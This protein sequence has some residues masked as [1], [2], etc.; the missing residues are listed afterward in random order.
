M[1]SMKLMKKPR[2]THSWRW[3]AF[4][5]ALLIAS[6]ACTTLTG[7]LKPTQAPPDTA[8]AKATIAATATRA[9]T[10]TK[11][12]S[13]TPAPTATPSSTATPMPGANVPL[14]DHGQ[15]LA[16]Q[17]IDSQIE[18]N[19]AQE[20][21]QLTFDQAMDAASTNAALQITDEGGQAVN[22]KVEW[23]DER[24][25]QFVPTTKLQAGKTYLARLDNSAASAAG[26][27]L[28]DRISLEFT[29][30]GE[31]Q[32]SQVF[33]ADGS[34][35]VASNAVI[36]VIFNR[37][38][39]P[40]VIAEEQANLPQPL[41]FDPPAAGEGEWINTSV[42]AFH[43]KGL[44][45]STAYR[46]SIA[47]GLPDALGE[48]SLAQ[49]FTWT[50]T[51]RSPGFVSYSLFNGA[52]GEYV[53]PEAYF[54]NVVPDA[55]FSIVFEQPM[56]RASVE[57]AISLV[58]E[59]GEAAP[60]TFDWKMEDTQVLI[61]PTVRL[62]LA[63][64][65]MLNLD[66]TAQATNG[67]EL[68]QG[69]QWPFSSVP[70]PDYWSMPSDGS[71]QDYYDATFSLHFVSPMRLDSLKD[72]V[73][74]KPA[75]SQP[76]EWYYYDWDW[77]LN[78]YNALQP[79][80]SYEVRILPGAEDLYGNAIQEERVVRFTTAKVQSNA[81]LMM[82]YM[83]LYRVGAVQEFY[84]NYQRVSNL[85]FSLYRLSATQFFNLTWPYNPPEDA[86]VWTK[87]LP[88]NQTESQRAYNKF[89]LAGEDTQP[90][91]PGFYFLGMDAGGVAH[92][93]KFVDSRTLIIAN[94]SLNLKT[95]AT[96]GL[97]WLTDLNSGAPLADAPV[98]IY[99]QDFKPIADGVTGEDGLLYLSLP[100][101]EQIWNA[102]Y[103]LSDD[104][105]TFAYASNDTGSG[106]NPWDFGIW[107]AY[108][109]EPA[110][111]V[112]YLYTDRPIYRPGQPV[113]FK[114]IVRADDDLRYSLPTATDVRL[115]ARTYDDEVIY[116]EILPL[117]TYGSFSG[118]FELDS[119]A[120]LGYYSM[121]VFVSGESNPVGNGYFTVA[122]YRKPEFIVNVSAAPQELLGGENFEAT[123]QADFYSGGGVGSA[124]VYWTLT[125]ENYYFAPAEEY[126]NFSFTD[127]DW[128]S[129]YYWNGPY[130]YGEMVAQGSGVTDANGKL[131][132]SVPAALGE[133]GGSRRLTFEATVS[134]PTG[135]PVSA[136]ASVTAH[137]SQVYAG[138][139]SLSYVG[140]ADKPMEIEV[141]ALDWGSEPV[142]G[143]T[144]DIEVVER[145]WS[146]IQKQDAQGRVTWEATVEETPVISFTA[147]TLDEKGLGR[148][149]FTPPNG[150]LFKAR[151]IAHDSLGNISR[152]STYLWVA[153]RD[154]IP[155]RVSNDRGFQL[156]SDRKSY[157]PGDTAEL[158]IASPFQ[159]QPYALVT[160]ERGHIR[161]YEVIRLES[162]SQVYR[163]PITADM[164]PNVYVSVLIVKGVDETSSKPDFRL[165]MLELKVDTSQQ[166]LKVELIPDKPQAGPG[167]TVTYQVRTTDLSGQPVSAE[168]SLSLSDLAALSLADPN[169]Q[170]LLDFFYNRRGLAVKTAVS[171]VN[172]IEDYNAVLQEY[173]ALG[174]GM[175]AGGGKGSDEWGVTA[176]RQ[177]FPDTAFWEGHLVTDANGEASVSVTLPDNLTTWR[178]DARAVTEDTRV[179]QTTLDLISTKPLLLRPQTPRFF[180]AGD[181]AVLG[182][183]VHN[184]T[185][186]ALSVDVS[187]QAE[188]LTLEGEAAQVIEI[189]AR[190]QAYVTWNVAVAPEATRVDVIFM[191]KSGEYEDATRPT[192]GVLDGQGIPVYRFEAPET[193][194]TAGI[195]TQAGATIEAI[196]LPLNFPVS[197]G[198]LTVSVSPSLA[199]GLADGLSYLE[200]YPYDCV[201]QT[202]SKFLPNVVSL[203]AMQAAGVS[204]P[205]LATRLEEEVYTALQRLYK[206]QNPDGGWGWWGDQE[207]NPTTSAYATFGLAELRLAGYGVDENVL[208][209]ALRYLRGQLRSFK[210]VS[211]AEP[212]QMN[213][214]AFILYVMAR[215]GEGA[216]FARLV[217]LYDLRE[218]LAL[219]A[220]A[221]LAQTIAWGDPSDPRIQTLLSDFNTAAINSATGAHWEE[222]SRDW[223]NW[224][225]DTRTTAIVLSALAELDAQNPLNA[226]AVRW[227][228]SNRSSGGH[229]QGTQE[230][231]WTILALTHWITASGE[232]NADYEYAI[233]LNGERL[234]GGVANRDTLKETYTL[235]LSVADLLKDEANRLA[236]A[237]SEGPGNLYYTAHLTVDLPVE[238]ISALD[239]GII[240]SR[241]YYRSDDR[242]TPV[243]EAAQG[244]LVQ[245]KLTIVVQHD[246]HY[247]VIDDPLP[248]GLEAV[249]QSL[250]TSQQAPQPDP[251]NYNWNDFNTYG[252]GWWIFNHV[253][254]RD[255]RVVLSAD[256]LPEGTYTYSYLARASTPGVFRVI[257][258]T[259]QEFYFPEVYGRGEGML[260]T[261]TP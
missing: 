237:R 209:D 186:E 128:D 158:L 93:G 199:A 127:I 102:R 126:T 190:Q 36:T 134:D 259:A 44:S 187:I 261:V 78:F 169:S 120:T 83:P 112:G 150:G 227:L 165:G 208:S 30:V 184:N 70:Y 222:S 200:N 221:Y 57:K 99:D 107:D 253:E 62:A 1:K 76:P 92:E 90:L 56:Q 173:V 7:P 194:G 67:G 212:Y 185:D 116:D 236:L 251:T 203:Q 191:A 32:V 65:Y 6:L 156:I 183:A 33:P 148:V 245:V 45:G 229:W 174:E 46:I 85:S 143:Q 135:N 61:T 131:T 108:Y 121:Q 155:W 39:I 241:S 86:L 95:T 59:N 96:E 249:D 242:A 248:A 175:G 142:A 28:A 181:Q 225:T 228:M 257:P 138:I 202:I 226:N 204:D 66:T 238:Q 73:I 111:S 101:P 82:P 218:N 132:V 159:G 124:E 224:N 213:R 232:L 260:F 189:P 11:A 130:N 255:E 23:I 195:A 140:Q 77:S 71:K 234:G 223:Q 104:G 123:I 252:W 157:T 15:A 12:A 146:S 64:A 14:D 216:D 113:Y 72:K 171:I 13:K 81:S 10:A 41:V 152:A 31:L 162:N 21:I 26:V 231:A 69:L 136:R 25:M 219:Y 94:A 51:T 29:A 3:L 211:G 74:F 42:Y 79:N 106:V 163:L 172:S 196:S 8:P 2:F 98:T 217:E 149:S 20:A 198:K 88:G 182:A 178:M 246:L 170:P 19:L 180:V 49:D 97:I 144:V 68:R 240:V 139:R 58:N 254:R 137:Q 60:L 233:G 230:T 47:A 110:A 193:V 100:K 177:D 235:T 17:L 215:A 192:L 145:K 168:V 258:P 205:D 63:R 160:V 141:V 125:A 115:V 9:A 179:G 35:D 147:I 114:G 84:A 214:Q 40:L 244:D 117:T 109:S 243:T 80:T 129:G 167:D 103:A 87:N 256:Y 54:V 18:Q 206:W 38:V 197:A 210:T 220:R 133:S 24:T 89:S 55:S 105:R 250:N 119:E 118:Q 4:L 52:S 16:P 188:G 166:Q 176:V 22:G 50:F 75:P 207:S 27:K 161:E 53:N 239:R 91:P 34:A 247:V 48:S 5:A 43:P 164:A 37:P 151:V 153:S 154:Y 201:E 122:E